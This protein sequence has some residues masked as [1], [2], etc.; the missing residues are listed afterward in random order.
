MHI[1]LMGENNLELLVD[2]SSIEAMRLLG[3]YSY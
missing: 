2:D 3:H 1:L